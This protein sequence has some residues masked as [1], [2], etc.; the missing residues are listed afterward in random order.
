ML[1]RQLLYIEN[2]MDKAQNSRE[3]LRV[4]CEQLAASST[5]GY[6]SNKLVDFFKGLFPTIVNAFNT[7]DSLDKLPKYE[8]LGKE[9]RAFLQKLSLHSYAELRGMR[10]YRPA[11]LHVSFLAYLKEL[12]VAVN[13]VQAFQAETLT[14]YL[15]FLAHLTAHSNAAL[16]TEEHRKEHQALAAK[17]DAMDA[18]FA[19]MFK[20]GDTSAETTVGVVTERNADWP[21]LLVQANTLS[22]KVE[23]LRLAT[24]QQMVKQAEDYLDMLFHQAQQGK[25]ENATPEVMQNLADGAYQIASEL[26]FLS[27]TYYRAI[28]LNQAIKDTMEKLHEAMK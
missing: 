24:I 9:H 4:A 26:E 23:S 19:K 20:P 21:E 13:H 11:G 6:A 10:A 18:A 7:T 15:T 5:A 25:L 27:V 28:V 12:D 1:C 17:R 3:E 22:N 2:I 8:G 16:S 14:P